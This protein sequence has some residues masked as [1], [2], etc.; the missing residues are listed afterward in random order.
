A[1]GRDA[2]AR[3]ACDVLW[4]RLRA[5]GGEDLSRGHRDTPLLDTPRPAGTAPWQG[6]WRRSAPAAPSPRAG[7]RARLRSTCPPYCAPYVSESRCRAP[8]RP[9]ALRRPPA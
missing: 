8:G 6:P 7:C 2:V 4:I 9:G 5:E 1:L 3:H